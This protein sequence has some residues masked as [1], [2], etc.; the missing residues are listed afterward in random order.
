MQDELVDFVHGFSQRTALATRWVLGTLGI[1]PQQFARWVL[2][3]GCLNRHNGMIPRDHWLTTEETNAIVQYHDAHPLD[4]YRRLA[5]MM[6]DADVVAVSPATAYRVL[7]AAGRL[8]RFRGKPSRKGTGFEQPLTPHEHWHVD[9]T[10]VNI[11]GTFYYLCSILDG[12]SRLLVHWELRERMTERD[13]ATIIQRALE[14]YPA[15]HPR[16]ISDNVLHPLSRAGHGRAP[17]DAGW[18]P[19]R[20]ER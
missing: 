16:I 6:L 20:G 5:F 9:V 11:V 12:Y 3:Y 15:A 13:V 19:R 17:A 7:K 14:E 1:H 2:R 10:Y 18:A 8:E 4:G